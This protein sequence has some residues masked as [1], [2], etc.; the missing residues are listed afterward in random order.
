[1]RAFAIDRFG[2]D[3][4][5]RELPAPVA[6]A[7]EVLVR[8]TLAG[9]NPVDWKIR[10]GLR[11]ERAFPFVLGSDFAGVVEAIGPGVVD[12][13]AG[14]RIFGTARVHGSF[15]EYTVVP[16]RDDNA[17]VAI[18]PAG[19]TDA[20]PAALPI[21]GV[22]A[23]GA[24][25]VL[26][27]PPGATLLVIGATGGVGALAVQLAKARGIHVIAAARST[28]EAFARGLG[29][30]EV[31]AY[32]RADVIAAVQAAHPGGVDGVYDAVS[33]RE[34]LKRLVTIVR[35][36]GRV[37]SIVRAADEAWFAGRNIV[38]SNIVMTQNPK[39]S[40][41]ELHQLARL[42]ASGA[43]RVFVEDTQPLSNAAEILAGLKAGRISGKYLLDVSN[44]GR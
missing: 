25:A 15:A 42:V 14:D 4:S 29:A 10:D 38:A 17:S 6:G 26:D 43:L 41:A 1:M 37:A 2:E 18:I 20:Q 16:Q 19:V 9:V 7:G 30:D 28:K 39:S 3:G 44:A 32:D 34:A 36:G 27:L 5:V 24:I 35:S 12:F 31:I 13:H 33:D 11:G 23:L 40:S 22:T 8:V 21:P